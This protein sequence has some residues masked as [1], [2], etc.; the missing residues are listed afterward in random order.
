MLNARGS[1]PNLVERLWAASTPTDRAVRMV[2]LAVTGSDEIH[3][4]TVME[5]LMES[6]RAGQPVKVGTKRATAMKRS[7]KKTAP[8][9]K[10]KRRSKASARKPGRR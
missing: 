9:K 7:V 8:P 2:V 1:A 6:I 4:V 5:A 3:G 10:A